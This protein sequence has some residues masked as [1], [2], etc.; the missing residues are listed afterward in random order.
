MTPS[1]AAEGVPKPVES[2]D[3][4]EQRLALWCQIR[5]PSPLVRL[6][7]VRELLSSSLHYIREL[8]HLRRLSTQNTEGWRPIESAPMDGTRILACNADPKANYTI[9][10]YFR[11]MQFTDGH[12]PMIPVTHWHPLLPPPTL[13]SRDVP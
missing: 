8:Q 13:A 5:E 11:G 3:E 7:S 1:Q 4:L 12:W 2:L 9:V 6:A 10:G